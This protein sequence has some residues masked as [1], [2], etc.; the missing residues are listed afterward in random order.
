MDIRTLTPDEIRAI[1]N[2]AIYVMATWRENQQH[3]CDIYAPHEP[4][5]MVTEVPEAVRFAHDILCILA[6]F[7][8]AGC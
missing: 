6:T 1:K 8:P 2:S 3:W 4:P 7:R 5:T